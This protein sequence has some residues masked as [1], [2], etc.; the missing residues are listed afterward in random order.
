MKT[1]DV[2]TFGETMILFQP[3][4]MMSLEYVHQFPKRIGGAESNVAIGL[5]RLGHSVGWFSKLGDDPFGRYIQKYIRG[6][7]VDT[8]SCLFTDKAPTGL[9]FKEQLSPEDLNVYYYRKG[10]AASLMEPKDLDETSIASAKILH[11]SGITPALSET[12][13]AAVMKAIE[14]AKQNGTKIVFDPNLRLKLW[15]S[16][17]AKR[18]LNEIA[19]SADV[20]LPGLDEGQLM[21]GKTEVEEVAEALMEDGNKTIIIKLG[22]K[23]AYLHTKDEKAY[24]DGFPVKQIVDPVGAGDGFAAG[25][26]SGI[27]REEPLHKVVRRANAIGA[28]VIGVSG[29]VEGLPTYA[30]VEQFMQP[31]GNVRDVKR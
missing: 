9:I 7:G 31:A 17:K 3:D 28:M 8:S 13:Y 4:Q 19:D 25:I 20:I 30:A 22:S 29:D 10:S 27:L 6:E 24:I 2:F 16:E 21:T 1:L 18:V 26:I 14:I 12:C 11:I 15:S 23:G 5:T